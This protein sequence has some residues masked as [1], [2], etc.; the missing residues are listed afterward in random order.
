L[1]KQIY[2]V[3]LVFAIQIDPFAV[4]IIRLHKRLRSWGE[5]EIIV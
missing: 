4:G 3:V 5:N 1:L 2:I